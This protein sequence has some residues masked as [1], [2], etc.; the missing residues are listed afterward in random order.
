MFPSLDNF[1]EADPRLEWLFP[2]M[3]SKRCKNEYTNQ[4]GR[5]SEMAT[6]TGPG[7]S[8][9]WLLFQPEYRHSASWPRLCRWS[10]NITRDLLNGG[11]TS[12]LWVCFTVARSDCR[13]FNT[14]DIQF[15]WLRG[16]TSTRLAYHDIVVIVVVIA[17][18]IVVVYLYIDISGIHVTSQLRTIAWTRF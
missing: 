14:L 10:V 7:S 3:M 5:Q 11:L 1:S 18:V 6:L 13:Y 8:R 16:V 4:G 15:Q 9:T 17:I 2:V 12:F